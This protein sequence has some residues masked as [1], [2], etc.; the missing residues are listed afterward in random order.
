[1]S[2]LK[3]RGHF[4]TEKDSSIIKKHFYQ[5]VKPNFAVYFAVGGELLDYIC[6]R[7]MLDEQTARKLIGQLVSAVSDMHNAGIVHR[8]LKI[9][10]FL[11]TESR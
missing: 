9:E 5:K 1:M 7:K 6:A 8:D 3:K 11:L 2:G 4:C 10:N